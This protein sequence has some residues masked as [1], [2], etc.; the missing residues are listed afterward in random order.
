MSTYKVVGTFKSSENSSIKYYKF[1]FFDN[2]DD[3][4]VNWVQNS[5]NLVK[6][7]VFNLQELENMKTFEI[8]TLDK[9]VFCEKA[10]K[11]LKDNGISYVEYN[12]SRNEFDIEELK[13]RMN[14]NRDTI[15]APVVFVNDVHVGGYAELEEMMSK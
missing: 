13:A 11:I 15:S 9:C 6:L 12:F 7:E 5:E 2:F 1:K 4:F 8:Y 3:N 14:T 10:K